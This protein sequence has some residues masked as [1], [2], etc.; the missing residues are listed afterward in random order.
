MALRI[1]KSETSKDLLKGLERAWTKHYGV[2]EIIRIDEAK[3]WSAA[4]VRDWCSDHGVE[5]EI[6][7]A[8]PPTT[9]LGAVERRHQV[10][11]RA[12]EL[13]MEDQNDRSRQS[14]VKGFSPAQWVLG[15]TP[16]SALGLTADMFDPAMPDGEDSASL[17][18]ANQNKRTAAQIAFLKADSDLHLR[19]VMNQNFRENPAATPQVGQKVFYWRI[20][21]TNIFQKNRWRGPARVVAVESNDS[22]KPVVLWLAHGTSLVRC[23]PHQVRPMVE[24]AGY[25]VPADPQAALADLQALRARGT[26]QFR[27]IAH[28]QP[29][30]K[31]EDCMSDYAP[32]EPPPAHD[33]DADN[34]DLDERI[35][36]LLAPVPV[37]G[38]VELAFQEMMRRPAGV[39]RPR[40]E[41][42]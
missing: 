18:A 21:G 25:N 17:F 10:V 4:L 35:D 32:A 15:K 30:P 8:H 16:A 34:E 37:P 19:R 26:T 7:P 40:S 31:V 28:N 2:P 27:D 41:L 38:A 24:D 29:E 9:F 23:A 12:L 3:G 33:S 13:F 42:R 6:A 14:T 11:R 36:A 22:H 1:L 20:Q 5:L 39:V